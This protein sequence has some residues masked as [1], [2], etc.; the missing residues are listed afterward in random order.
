[1]ITHVN[2]LHLGLDGEYKLK[3][4][5]DDVPRFTSETWINT[6]IGSV[7]ESFEGMNLTNRLQC[8][9]IEYII[10]L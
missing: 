6:E 2:I 5:I 8:N 10:M 4:N 3:F 7:A 9:Q 1:M